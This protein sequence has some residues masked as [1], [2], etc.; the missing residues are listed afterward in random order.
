M[1]TALFFQLFLPLAINLV[2]TLITILF[3]ERRRVQIC[4]LVGAFVLLGGS[5]WYAHEQSAELIVVPDILH[6]PKDAADVLCQK[7]GLRFTAVAGKWADP[8]NRVQWQSLSPGSQVKP[9]ALMRVVVFRG[10]P[11]PDELFGFGNGQIMRK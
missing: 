10:Q 6:E 11:V 9:G 1:F 4:V 7:L 5:L 2:S 8:P 3:C